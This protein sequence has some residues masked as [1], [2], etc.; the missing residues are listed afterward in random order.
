MRHGGSTCGRSHC[1]ATIVS[2]LVHS[3]ISVNSNRGGPGVSSISS[4]LSSLTCRMAR[5]RSH[6]YANFGFVNGSFVFAESG[7]THGYHAIHPERILPS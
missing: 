4:G 2:S 6:E 7:L 5:Y 3:F 1:I